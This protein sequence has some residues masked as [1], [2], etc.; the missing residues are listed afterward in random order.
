MHEPLE[1]AVLVTFVDDTTDVRRAFIV[2]TSYP[3]EAVDLVFGTNGISRDCRFEA[4]RN[5]GPE[6]EGLKVRGV[7]EIQHG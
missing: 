6:L 5:E 7:M 4:T 1:T 3:D 2:G